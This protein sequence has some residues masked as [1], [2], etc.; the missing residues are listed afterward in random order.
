MDDGSICRH[1]L[2]LLHGVGNPRHSAE[3]ASNGSGQ[4]VVIGPPPLH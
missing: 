1:S 4:I 3:L 2:H